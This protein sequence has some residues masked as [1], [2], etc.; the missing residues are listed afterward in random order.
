MKPAE[1][2]EAGYC[3]MVEIRKTDGHSSDLVMRKPQTIAQHLF[4]ELVLND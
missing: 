1:T 2:A 3:K 4:R